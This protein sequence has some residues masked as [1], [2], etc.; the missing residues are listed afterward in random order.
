VQLFDL[1]MRAHSPDLAPAE[2]ARAL[3]ETDALYRWFLPLLT[4]DTVPKFVQLI[5]LAQQCV[6]QGHER[7]RA[8]RL[9]LEGAEREDAL[10][11]IRRALAA[12]PADQA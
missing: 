7:M 5:K 6:G 4:L 12:L 1:A 10:G 8:P 9:V 11:I 3:A 2:R